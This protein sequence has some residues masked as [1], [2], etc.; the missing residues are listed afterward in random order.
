MIDCIGFLTD[1]ARNMPQA[2]VSPRRG[3]GLKNWWTKP[4]RKAR[5]YGF[6]SLWRRSNEGDAGQADT[7]NLAH[8]R[9]GS[10]N[11]PAQSAIC[12]IEIGFTTQRIG[13]N[14]RCKQTPGPSSLG[15]PAVRHFQQD[16][17]MMNPPTKE[18]AETL[19]PPPLSVSCRPDTASAGDPSATH[20]ARPM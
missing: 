13:T 18:L 6:C 5:A 15:L 20:T 1:F 8:W 4:H 7:L 17:L 9:S 2:C 10:I 3:I 12:R 11:V 16:W 19:R 14:R